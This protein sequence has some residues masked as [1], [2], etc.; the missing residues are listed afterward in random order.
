[1]VPSLGGTRF[2]VYPIHTHIYDTGPHSS[3]SIKTILLMLTKLIDHAPLPI[4]V[5]DFG[6]AKLSSDNYT[7]VSTRYFRVKL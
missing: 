3:R 4:Q 1:M 6:L 5:A 2:I 7:H